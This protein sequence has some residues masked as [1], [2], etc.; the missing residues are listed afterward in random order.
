[1]AWHA[2]SDDYPTDIMATENMVTNTASA[3][4]NTTA[5]PS[6]TLGLSV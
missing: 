4:M 5:I 2:R 6:S 3:S 1:M